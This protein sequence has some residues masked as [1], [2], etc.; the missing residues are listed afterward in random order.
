MTDMVPL[1]NRPAEVAD[2]L[3]AGHLEGDLIIGKNQGSSIGTIVDR[4]T[5]FVLRL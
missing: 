2:R 1:K 3:V 5:R 4:M